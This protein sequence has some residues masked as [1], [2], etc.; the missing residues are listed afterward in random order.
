MLKPLSPEQMAANH[1]AASRRRPAGTRAPFVLRN[2]GPAL[3]LGDLVY[4]TFR[5]RAY[6][7]P[8]LPWRAGQRLQA[9]WVEAMD[10]PT[11]LTPS[12]QPKYQAI[13]AQLPGLLWKHCRPVG[14]VLRALRILGL[15]RN[16]FEGASEQE[17]VE[18]AAFFLK[19][20]TRSSIQPLPSRPA[21]QP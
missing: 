3:E 9:L 11:P 8:P 5:G 14:L 4:F 7:I 19:R 15:L 16:P 17:L 12:T 13:I 10:L 6:G 2:M 1:Q 18:A 20:R 21:G